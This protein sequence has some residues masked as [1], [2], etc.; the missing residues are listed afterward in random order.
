L[1]LTCALAGDLPVST[2]LRDLGHPGRYF[3]LFASAHELDINLPTRFRVVNSRI[4]N[5]FDHA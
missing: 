5:E 2:S 3:H 4:C 1:S